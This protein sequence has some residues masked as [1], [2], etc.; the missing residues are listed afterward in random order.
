[1]TSRCIIFLI[2]NQLLHLH[3]NCFKAA[4]I[5]SIKPSANSSA[6][7]GLFNGGT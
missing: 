4:F 3:F 7:N 1:M 5:T 2:I 6:E